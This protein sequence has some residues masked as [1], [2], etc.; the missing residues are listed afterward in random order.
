MSSTMAAQARPAIEGLELSKRYGATQ[1]IEGVSIRLERGKV[2]ALVGE[3]GA[4]KSTLIRILTGIEQPDQGRILRDGQPLSLRSRHDATSAGIFCVYQDHPFVP[5]FEVY[6]QV[7]LGYEDHFTRRG[8]L[9]DG[10]MRKA[11]EDLLA[12]LNL[13]WISP[14]RRMG[15]LTPAIRELVALVAVVGASRALEV[16]HPIILLDEPTSA[17]T[18]EEL[19]TL[20][21]FIDSLRARSAIMFVSHR[22][23]EV[24]DWSDHISVLRDGHTVDSFSRDEASAD[25][26]HA[27]MGGDRR[28]VAEAPEPVASA[29]AEATHSIPA[30]GAA[31]FSIQ[32]VRLRPYAPPFDFGIQPG[33]VVG[34]AGVEGSGKEDFLRTCV[35]LPGTTGPAT[36][37]VDGKVLPRRLRTLLTSGLAYLSGDRQAEGVF[38]DLAIAENIALSRRVASGAGGFFVSWGQ[39]RD[40]AET[41]R[42][43]LAIRA[44][45]VA[46]PL[47]SLSGGN[48]QKVLLARLLEL[49]PRVLLLDN[50]TRGVDVG[51]KASIYELFRRLASEGVSLVVAGDDLEELVAVS[52]RVLVLKDGRRVHDFDNKRRATDPGDI[53]SRMVRDEYAFRE[54]A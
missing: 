3:N 7:F 2:T 17:L 53:L 21:A 11:S 23:N 49:S 6:R 16:E 34:L 14:S 28:P 33:E 35:G 41:L 22:I 40:R 30:D 5:S 46:A 50:V 9:L 51:T 47:R 45:S 42:S 52:D 32:G 18:A 39:E 10:A 20:T 29:P 27:A 37:E 15:E 4:G 13:P 36:V 44:A 8:I 48:Q 24:L 38:G 31:R 54:T 26:I 12:E 1:A 43:T 25:R 19:G